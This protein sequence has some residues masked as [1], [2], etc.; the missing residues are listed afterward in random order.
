MTQDS[1]KRDFPLALSTERIS[2]MQHNI[3]VDIKMHELETHLKGHIETYKQL[4]Q[5]WIQAEKDNDSKASSNLLHQAMPHTQGLI[6]DVRSSLQKLLID[7]LQSTVDRQRESSKH[8]SAAIDSEFF[9]DIRIVFLDHLIRRRTLSIDFQ[10]AFKEYQDVVTRPKKSNHDYY[11]QKGSDLIYYVAGGDEARL[12]ELKKA[13][14]KAKSTKN[15]D[16]KS[17]KVDAED[18]RID[19]DGPAPGL[20]PKK[21][22]SETDLGREEKKKS[23]EKKSG[24]A[25]SVIVISESEHQ[26]NNE[27]DN[28]VP[29]RRKDREDREAKKPAHAS[30]SIG[31]KPPE[32][33]DEADMDGGSSG[34]KRLAK[35][36]LGAAAVVALHNTSNKAAR[37]RRSHRALSDENYRKRS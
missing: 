21:E 35:L 34:S 8:F 37:P 30:S 3:Q 24:I 16:S 27:W 31:Y 15:S 26:A 6:D 5:K 20:S 10:S 7:D 32:I 28:W 11:V 17:V 36:G 2:E 25:D 12:D 1:K 9:R 13:V 29:A 18:K 33:E 4:E 14:E 19:G 22:K 23:K